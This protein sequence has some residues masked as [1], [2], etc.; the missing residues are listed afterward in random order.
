MK[1]DIEFATDIK[2]AIDNFDSSMTLHTDY[3]G[4]GMYGRKCFGVSS[5]ESAANVL[6]Q[7]MCTLLNQCESTLVAFVE[8]FPCQEIQS[9]SL[10][11]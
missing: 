4:R 11:V 3:S 6:M 1:I 8:E 2:N 10:W 9:D 5:R 7:L